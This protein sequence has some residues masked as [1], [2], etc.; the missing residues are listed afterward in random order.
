MRRQRIIG[1]VVG[2]LLAGGFVTA[3]ALLI[4]PTNARLERRPQFGPDESRPIAQ[5]H[6]GRTRE[7]LLTE[8]GE[9]TRVGPWQ[10]GMPRQEVFDK[11]KGL[12]TLEWHWPSGTFLAS[13]YPVGG[14]WI[15]FDSHW[16]PKGCILE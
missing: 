7:Q 10:I 1:A 12:E 16:V 9:P 4:L 6:V 2:L 3:I 15:C 5:T 13:V 14:R 11:Y 8:L